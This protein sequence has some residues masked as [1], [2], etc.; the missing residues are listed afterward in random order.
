MKKNLTILAALA[1]GTGAGS[2]FTF[3]ADY[4]ALRPA[5]DGIEYVD[6]NATEIYVGKEGI[7]GIDQNPGATTA[8]R[9]AIVKDG[10]GTLILKP[11]VGGSESYD[12]NHSLVVREG[13]M[14]MQG[15]EV[16][17]IPTL[18]SPNLTVGG[19][20]AHLI[21]EGATY[22][23]SINL[24]VPG[25]AGYSSAI[26]I[27]GRDGDG[28]LTLRDGST[29]TNDQAILA[30]YPSFDTLSSS[31]T[32]N[33]HVCGTYKTSNQADGLY[34]DKSYFSSDF[35]Y[36]GGDPDMFYMS[37]AVINVEGGSTLAAGTFIQ[38]QNA[39]INIEGEGSVLRDAHHA[40]SAAMDNNL[41]ES[42]GSD[43]GKYQPKTV[44]NIRDGGQFWLQDDV[45]LSYFNGGTTEINVA[46]AGSVLQWD[47]ITFNF[48]DPTA[49]YRSD[50]LISVKDGAS[51]LVKEMYMGRIG[52]GERTTVV[53]VEDSLS[54]YEGELLE[55]Y[56]DALFE[57]RGTTSIDKDFYVSASGAFVNTKDANLTLGDVNLANS[58]LVEAGAYFVND[59]QMTT[60]I[61]LV[62]QGTLAGS[63]QMGS[64][65]TE[66][67]STVYVGG[68]AVYDDARTKVVDVVSSA[69]T[70]HFSA[71]TLATGTTLQFYVDGDVAATEQSAGAGTYSNLSVDAGGLTA[72][73]GL[74]AELTL[75]SGT[76]KAALRRVD[77]AVPLQLVKEASADPA[78]PAQDKTVEMQMNYL[79][80]GENANLFSVSQDGILRLSLTR[81]AVDYF[82]RYGAADL[83]NTLWTST[84]T[85]QDFARK[86]ASQLDVARRVEH[87]EGISL[88]GAG[89]GYFTS[90]S[91]A[92]GFSY[93]SGG[94]AV[95]CDAVLLPQ[96]RVGAAFGQTFGTF[97][98]DSAAKVDQDALMFSLYGSADK[99]LGDRLTLRTSA[100]AAYGSV[101]NDARTRYTDGTPGRA[102]WEDDVWT[103]GLE[104]ALQYK[105]TE[106]FSV[107]PFVGLDYVYGDQG[108]YA[109]GFRDG[110]GRTYRGGA[111]QVWRVPVGVKLQGSVPLG[112]QQYL[113]PE[114]T[115]AYVGDISRSNPHATVDLYGSSARVHGS[116]PGRSAFML[117]AG[118][119]WKISDQWAAGASY[120]VEA[121]DDQTA[122]G[123]NG[124]VRFSF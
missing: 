69:G 64:V 94:Y 96:A 15:V 38:T 20:Q 95:G 60:N 52:T 58:S 106:R 13:T 91:G 40:V 82:V 29:M 62:L 72:D 16:S 75:G 119:T 70:P 57:N 37:K 33:A 17:N 115:V 2:Q 41:G 47:G 86:A 98:A 1:L 21:L 24:G 43:S 59:G 4:D 121:R 45:T 77:K 118:V 89:L 85:V 36:S 110:L 18:E 120:Q 90:M 39:E 8:D 49:I 101:D 84:G 87:E 100:Y 65:V 32:T 23:Q 66:Q 11:E 19:N 124:Y 76:L 28:T 7:L 108:T 50:S 105:V 10:L 80:S 104:A 102:Q 111:M 67:G 61:D 30:G 83:L 55:I 122:Q 54:T 109:E 73:Q 113:F 107:S 71:L 26:V 63:G 78:A 79:L 35:V 114:L 117:N 88:W 81:N 22:E 51:A 12:I 123:V 25:G 97:R 6:A 3:A 27:G 14:I 5:R 44:V 93:D 103:F 99:K 9:T 112:A 56:A 34:R 68:M 53:R 92:Q 74:V 46:G 48:S 31:S 42:Y 116:N